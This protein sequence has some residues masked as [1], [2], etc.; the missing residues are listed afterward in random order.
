MMIFP[1]KPASCFNKQMT[2]V[3]WQLIFSVQ[4]IIN[5]DWKETN[6]KPYLKY[7]KQYIK[8][9]T[10]PKKRSIYSDTLSFS[11]NFLDA[12]LTSWSVRLFY[13]QQ[14]RFF[15]IVALTL[16]LTPKQS[17]IFP[18]LFFKDWITVRRCSVWQM[19]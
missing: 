3:L 18:F 9:I 2:R 7:A 6:P 8:W 15:Q 10:N 17:R 16:E 19:T 14:T 12:A 1:A 5:P 13:P 4:Q 11:S